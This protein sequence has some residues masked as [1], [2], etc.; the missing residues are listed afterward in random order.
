MKK[1]TKKDFYAHMSKRLNTKY[2]NDEGYSTLLEIIE[3]ASGNDIIFTDLAELTLMN[4]TDRLIYRN[5][6]AC[7]GKELTPLQVNEYLA[8]VEYGLEYIC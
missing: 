8:I 3:V 1:P 2:K 6:L 7:E 5:A 4:K